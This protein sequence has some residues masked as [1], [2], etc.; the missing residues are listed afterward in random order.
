MANQVF[1]NGMEIACKA[2]A[3]KVIASF[4]DVCMTPPENPATPP[5][6]PV[7]YPST[8]FASDTTGGSKN[9]KISDKEIMLKN[10]SYFKTSV[11]DEAGC[12]AKKGLISSKNKGKVYFIKWSMDVKVEGENVDR[13]LDMTTNNHGSPTANEA[14]PWPQVSRMNVPNLPKRPCN[15]KCPKKPT[16]ER[17]KKLRSGTPTKAARKKLKE[18]GKKCVACRS[19]K[20]TSPDH[21]VP[22]SIISKMPGFACL[23]DENQKKMA[24]YPD[25]FVGLCRSCNS[26]KSDTLW[27]K[28]KGH[29]RRELK[30][31]KPQRE[32]GIKVT[33]NLIVNL[34]AEIKMLTCG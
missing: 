18:K 7:P 21:I 22:L 13:H 33:G 23:S 29:K 34:K 2:G 32:K 8:G 12:A 10:K 17:Y 11:G 30:W 15:S 20:G 14:I 6:I 19:R 4:P 16:P 5:G 26:S 28:W 1:A 27:Q 25:N 9:V 31:T 3:G 24:N